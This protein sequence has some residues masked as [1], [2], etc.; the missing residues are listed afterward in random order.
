V[1]ELIQ[2]RYNAV[3]IHLID[4]EDKFIEHVTIECKDMELL[5]KL[6]EVARNY[7]DLKYG[8]SI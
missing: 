3:V 7:Q 5:P 1:I 8:A 6:Q 4:A 2:P